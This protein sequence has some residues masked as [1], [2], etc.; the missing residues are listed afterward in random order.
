MKNK[1]GLGSVAVIA[2]VAVVLVLGGI[3]YYVAHMPQ[4]PLGGQPAGPIP[5]EPVPATSTSISP[6]SSL[7]LAVSPA[8][9]T[10][11]AA[12]TAPIV[13]STYRATDVAL[14]NNQFAVDLYS[15]YA[16]EAGADENMFFSPF[17][18]S[19]AMAM[20]YEGAKGQTAMEIGNVFHFPADIAQLRSGYQHAFAAINGSSSDYALNTANALWVQKSYPLLGNYTNVVK[21]YYGGSITNLDFVNSP[22]FA[23]STI[24]RWVSDQTAGKI[25][26]IL[27]AGDVDAHTRLIL[28]NAIYFK[29]AW[30]SQF[31]A[32]ATQ[33]K[34]FT[35][36]SGGQELVSMMEQTG[37]FAYADLGNAQFLKLPYKG[38]DVSMF[39]LLPKSNDLAT[40]GASLSGTAIAA[41]EQKLQGALVNV[42]L[43][44]FKVETEKHMP[45]DLSAL[46]MPT[47]FSST[48]ADFSGMA[49]IV[50][51]AQN[52]Y[53]S[54]VV[55]KAFIDVDENGT[56]AAAATA[57]IMAKG[58]AFVSQP[59]QPII[60][61]ANHPFLFFIQENKTGNILFVG[62]VAKP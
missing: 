52:L 29:G 39:V 28:T 7:P 21:A 53:V 22:T 42:S 2:A 3:W 19:S 58:S 59:P 9:T 48:A 30:S 23:V 57:V 37:Q 34:N 55:H 12:A 56:E 17:S 51:P 50:D 45:G 25:P 18:I 10:G 32:G 15:R 33:S 62:R 5:V 60:F 6:S 26:T 54:D 40:V 46:G 43:P 11:R 31:E 14:A 61:N 4:P 24:N 13:A 27:A 8:T 38:D 44:K 41:G 49:K 35:T 47:A 16:G 36:G 20:V 1:N